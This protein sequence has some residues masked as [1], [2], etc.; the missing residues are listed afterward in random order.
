MLHDFSSQ[1]FLI[2]ICNLLSVSCILPAY[3]L[4]LS[5]YRYRCLFYSLLYQHHPAQCLIHHSSEQ[6]FVGKKIMNL[7]LLQP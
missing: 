3:Y 7:S 5:D 1:N 4:I 2:N 6:L